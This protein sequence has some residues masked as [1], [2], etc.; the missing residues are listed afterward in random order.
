MCSAVCAVTLRVC[1]NSDGGLAAWGV[2]ECMLVRSFMQ[3]GFYWGR[4]VQ[5]QCL[6]LCSRN[7][8]VT[9]IRAVE[10]THAARCSKQ[11]D[12]NYVHNM[13]RPAPLEWDHLAGAGFALRC[14][15]CS[16]GADVMMGH[17]Y[18]PYGPRGRCEWLC[19]L[20]SESVVQ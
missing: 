11:P 1:E 9:Q 5:Q 7:A 19:E 3:C 10:R 20:C 12:N 2:C 14:W 16:A 8:A 18:G 15:L 4:V 17:V 6:S 13:H